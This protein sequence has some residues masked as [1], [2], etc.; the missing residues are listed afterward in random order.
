MVAAWVACAGYFTFLRQAETKAPSREGGCRSWFGCKREAELRLRGIFSAGESRRRPQLWP[1]YLWI[2]TRRSL[3]GRRLRSPR[4]LRQRLAF[5]Q[6][7]YFVSVDHLALQQRL[8]DALE[9]FSVV[10][11]ERLRLVVTRVDDA[12]HFLVDL[13]RGIFR[14]IAMLVDL[15]SQEDCFVFFPERERTELAHAPFAHHVASDFRRALDVVARAGGDVTEENFLGRATAHQYCEHGLEIFARVRV[16]VVFRQLH[17]QAQRHTA[18]N[19][20]HFVNWIGARRHRRNQRVSSL[21]IRG[22]LFLFVRQD[23]RLTLDAH[24][25]FVFR[26]FEIGHHHVLAVLARRPQRGFVH[27][28]RQVGARKSRSAARDDREIDV[29]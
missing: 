24:Q 4:L 10:P 1:N 9:H 17:G 29:V 13:D 21:V 12:A 5:H 28:I 8:R 19:D 15:A 6:Q 22:V 27:Q 2:R 3:W 25:H 26:H 14:I 18:R 23:H 16:L 11:K 7:L 20:R